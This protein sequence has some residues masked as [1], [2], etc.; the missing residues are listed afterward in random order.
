MREATFRAELLPRP[1]STGGKKEKK[2]EFN[3]V[4][5][6]WKYTVLELFCAAVLDS[7]VSFN[8]KNITCCAKIIGSTSFRGHLE[9][10]NRDARSLDEIATNHIANYV[11]NLPI[12]EMNGFRIQEVAEKPSSASV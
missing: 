8:V 4:M 1:T 2:R 10:L 11:L 9:A 7:G 12:I 6:R 3:C 5:G